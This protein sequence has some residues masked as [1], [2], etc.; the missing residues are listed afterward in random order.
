MSER[1]ASI[2]STQPGTS[3]QKR[4]GRAVFEGDAPLFRRKI[5]SRNRTFWWC[6]DGGKDRAG[7]IHHISQPLHMPA[8]YL[9]KDRGAW[10]LD[11]WIG[12]AMKGKWVRGVRGGTGARGVW[13]A[14][15]RQQQ[16]QLTIIQYF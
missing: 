8:G 2:R 13:A 4:C 16:G 15:A 10:L 9:K 5:E 7:A 11:R 6:V 12:G 3:S 1:A 14:H